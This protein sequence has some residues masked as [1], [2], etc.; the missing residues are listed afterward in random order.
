[1]K[2]ETEGKGS[3]RVGDPAAVETPSPG[4]LLIS[5]HQR[6][7]WCTGI[8]PAQGFIVGGTDGREIPVLFH[9]G[10]SKGSCKGSQLHL[11]ILTQRSGWT[12]PVWLFLPTACKGRYYSALILIAFG[13]ASSALGMRMVS[14]PCFMAASILSCLTG[15]LNSMARL[16]LPTGSSLK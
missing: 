15:S 10:R 9:G 5:D 11:I 14:S 2:D 8:Y 1:M 13:L 7:I 6:E 12:A 4:S 3:P 16:N